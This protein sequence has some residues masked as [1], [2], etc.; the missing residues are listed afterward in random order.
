MPNKPGNKNWASQFSTQENIANRVK[1]RR[2]IGF[3]LAMGVQNLKI[4]KL[5][6]INNLPNSDQ[7]RAL[8]RTICRYNPNGSLTGAN[9]LYHT[10]YNPTDRFTTTI[11]VVFESDE[12]NGQDPQFIVVPTWKVKQSVKNPVTG[13]ESVGQIVFTGNMPGSY[14]LSSG[15]NLVRVE[16]TVQDTN[17]KNTYVPA[18][19]GCNLKLIVTWEPNVDIEENE[20]N[21]LF[22]R[23]EISEQFIE[24][25]NNA[26]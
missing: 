13:R 5:P 21:R 18:N 26:A 20:K 1:P 4:G 8:E 17:L 15:M 22:A 24:L 9:T 25:K 16:T 2:T 23:C 11:Y 10:V 19:K 14:E 6:P 7:R 3:T 12:S